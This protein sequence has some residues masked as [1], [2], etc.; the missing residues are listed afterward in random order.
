MNEEDRSKVKERFLVAYAV[1]GNISLSCKAANIAR[2]TFYDWQEKDEDF[3]FKF[4]Q[5]DREFADTML[6][7]FVQRARDGY[8]KPVV[9]AGRMV[10]EDVP[11]LDRHGNQ[12]IDDFGH[13]LFERKPLMERVV[14]DSLL[15][16]AVKKHFPEYREKQQIDVTQ[17]NMSKDVQE[18]HK[19][20][21]EAL[22]PYPE[23]KIALAE[24]IAKREQPS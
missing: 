11:I 8:Q 6:A 23:A 3:S 17:T 15:A 22:D 19:A 21:A 24:R 1:T 14:S 2:R 18:L 16:M 13:P 12:V 20:I 5:A 4:H 9:S 10:Y 7:E